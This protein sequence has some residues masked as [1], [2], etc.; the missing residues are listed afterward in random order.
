MVRKIKSFS[1]LR[2]SSHALLCLQFLQILSFPSICLFS[3]VPFARSNLRMEALIMRKGEQAN[4]T[5]TTVTRSFSNEAHYRL[6]E[7]YVLGA[8]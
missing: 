5:N 3:L 8:G 2:V 6:L 7:V 4:E 1:T